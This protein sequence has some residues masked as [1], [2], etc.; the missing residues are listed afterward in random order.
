MGAVDRMERRV[1]QDYCR[2]VAQGYRNHTGYVEMFVN[3][4]RP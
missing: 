2:I 1:F 4:E 3:L